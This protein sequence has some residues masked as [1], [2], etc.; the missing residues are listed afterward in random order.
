MTYDLI[1]FMFLIMI[2]LKI[3]K[4]R[5]NYLSPLRGIKLFLCPDQKEINVNNL[6]LFSHLS[7]NSIKKI[8]PSL[9]LNTVQ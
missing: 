5:P 3:K 9:N 4:Y 6:F 2:L 1:F 7:S 8:N